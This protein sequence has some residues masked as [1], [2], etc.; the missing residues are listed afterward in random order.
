MKTLLLTMLLLSFTVYASTPDFIK[1]CMDCHGKNGVSVESDVPTIAGASA[2]FIEAS[3]FAYKDDIRPAVES[4]YRS[5]DTERAAT[6]M[7]TVTEQLSDEQILQ[8]AKYFSSKF[9]I[10]AK[11]DF[12]ARLATIGKRIHSKKCQKCHEDGGTSA[13]DDSGILAGQ[14]TPYLKESMKHFRDGS[15]QTDK[16]MKKKV[17]KL[18]DKEWQALL[19]Y[20]ASQQ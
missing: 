13:E 1:S 5:G 4:K 16:K 11:Q 3:L 12:D 17:D 10:T 2:A 20:Y 19:A 6:D 9:F 14:W 15:R 8:S 7:K 18:G